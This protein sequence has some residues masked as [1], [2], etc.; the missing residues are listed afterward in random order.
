MNPRSTQPHVSGDAKHGPTRKRGNRSP[1]N[2]PEDERMN[3]GA[4]FA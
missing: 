4:S 2:R 3:I 1:G